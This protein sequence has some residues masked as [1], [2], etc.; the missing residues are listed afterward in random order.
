MQRALGA[1]VLVCALASA[2]GVFVVQRRWSFLGDGLAHA[3]FGGAALGLLLGAPPLLVATPF[4]LAIAHGVAF[5]SAR[6]RLATDTAIGILFA[7][8]MAL[9]IIFLS[10]RQAATA[11]AFTY[12]FGSILAVTPLDL[13]LTGVLALTTAC[14]IPSYWGRWAYATFDRDQA[15]ADRLN[16]VRDDAV[17]MTLLALTVVCAIKTVGAVLITAFL[18]I[19]PA[20]ARLLATTFAR[21]T[22]Y[23]ALIGL[24]TTIAGLWLSYPLDLPS[25]PVIILL[26]AAA[27]FVALTL[28]RRSF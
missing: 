8:S 18:T 9:G 4:T 5:I 2:L 10:L 21:M 15:L 24:A 7:C 3:A 23:S 22:L 26:Q 14:L 28:R 6:S 11:D 19:P 25:G 17:L 16:V 27:F 12:L 1:G 13:A 20:T